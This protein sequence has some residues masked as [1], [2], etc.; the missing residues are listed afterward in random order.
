MQ[1]FVGDSDHSYFTVIAA[2]CG[3]RAKQAAASG[4]AVAL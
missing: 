2:G 1:S 3:T 4:R